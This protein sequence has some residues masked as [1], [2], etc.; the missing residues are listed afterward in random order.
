MNTTAIT[1]AGGS[2]ATPQNYE[3]PL[4]SSAH[5]ALTFAYNHSGQV[6]DRPAMARAAQRNTSSGKGLGGVAGA[7]Q[8][9]MIL[10]AVQD[11]P[12]L[13]QAILRARF[14]G[15]GAK[16]PHCN[17]DADDSDWLAAVREISDA[18]VASAMSSHLTNRKLRDGIIARYF[19][20]KV[21]LS[22]AARAAEVSD[23]TASQHNGMI[24][25]W[26][27]GTRTT[28]EQGGDRSDGK[29]GQ[30]QIA[31]EAITDLLAGK[32]LF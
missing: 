2:T 24:I 25:G 16:C 7:A 23:A 6:Y 20:K 28:K 32:G 29:K 9:G 27:R 22:A 8:A 30:E 19:G 5:A 21:L 26:L 15:R 31:M 14:G 12:R 10:R 4:F 1:L 11:L 17:A 3:A 13:H 18:A